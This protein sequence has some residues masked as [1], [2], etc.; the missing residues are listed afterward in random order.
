MLTVVLVVML[1]LPTKLSRL[2]RM[3]AIRAQLGKNWHSAKM[4]CSLP[5]TRSEF[6]FRS[7]AMQ[8]SSS[9]VVMSGL[10]LVGAQILIC[11]Q[12]A[13]MSS[14]EHLL[15]SMNIFPWTSSPTVQQLSSTLAWKRKNLLTHLSACLASSSVTC[16]GSDWIGLVRALAFS[17]SCWPSPNSCSN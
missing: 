13:I 17:T 7:S 10:A 16:F 1:I 2:S 4:T 3:S 9:R 15:Y 5:G 11:V 8:K 6:T 12:L 14:C